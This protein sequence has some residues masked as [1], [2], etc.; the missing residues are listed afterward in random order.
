MRTTAA[1]LSLR[2][3]TTLALGQSPPAC[4]PSQAACPRLTH[5][6]AFR[7]SMHFFRIH[8]SYWRDRLERAAAMGI[9]TVEVGGG[10]HLACGPGSGVARMTHT[11]DAA[12]FPVMACSMSLV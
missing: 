11:A 5:P 4:S 12:A 1:I 6:P 7:C 8:P 9:N 3:P 2:L 10:K